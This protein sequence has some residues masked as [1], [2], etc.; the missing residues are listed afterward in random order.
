[1]AIQLI[2]SGKYVLIPIDQWEDFKKALA[3]GHGYKWD[4]LLKI[5]LLEPQEIEMIS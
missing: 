3:E 2:P 5:T 4:N 1:M